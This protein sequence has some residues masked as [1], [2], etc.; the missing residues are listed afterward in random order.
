VNP[1]GAA[2]TNAVAPKFAVTLSVFVVPVPPRVLP[3]DIAEKP[4][5]LIPAVFVAGLAPALGHP[6]V[7]PLGAVPCR[8]QSYQS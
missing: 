6:D 3:G 4:E 8:T 2:S 7:K 5:M 1:D